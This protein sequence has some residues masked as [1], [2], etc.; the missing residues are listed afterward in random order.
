MIFNNYGFYCDA[1][2]SIKAVYL[3]I[4]LKLFQCWLNYAINYTYFAS[5]KTHSADKGLTVQGKVRWI[6]IKKKI[7]SIFPF[8]HDVTSSKL[9]NALLQFWNLPFVLTEELCKG[10]FIFC[11]ELVPWLTQRAPLWCFIKYVTLFCNE[12]KFLS[13][14]FVKYV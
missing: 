4:E 3:N 6:K 12:Y 2:Y 11:R 8:V 1:K 7:K 10:K 5:Q 14:V 13:L 9:L